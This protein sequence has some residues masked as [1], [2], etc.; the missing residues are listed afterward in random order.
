MKAYWILLLALTGIGAQTL[1][2]KETAPDYFPKALKPLP[3]TQSDKALIELGRALFY[4]PIL[5][6]DG[7]IS[8]ASCH[9][10][11]NGFAHSDH[12]TS[13]GIND[14]VG[15]R[16]APALFNLAWQKEFMWDGAVNNLEMQA[17]APLSHPDEMGSNLATTLNK[18]NESKL[19]QELSEAAYG[20]RVLDSRNFLHALGS[21]LLNLRSWQSKYDRV[22]H[23]QTSFNEQEQRGYALFQSHCNGC[24]TEPLFF[25]NEFR[26]NG[27]AVDSI[28]QDSGRVAVSLKTID[29]YRFKTP[30]LRNLSYTYP[31]MHD[32]RFD[33][34]NQVLRH[35]SAPAGNSGNTDELI[36]KGLQLNSAERT[37]LIAFLLC[38]NDSSFVFNPQYAFPRNT[39]LKPNK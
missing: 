9:S 23:G 4:D 1:I 37:D 31:Y 35:Y 5:S 3:D 14:H 39:L 2:E 29:R 18:L 28:L 26:N 25:A 21:F 7:S 22:K 24:H 12:R 33:N 15:K 34:L 8:C 32:G 16:N 20:T 38:L 36:G 11:Y 19:Y 6:A 27:L 30:S 13:H 17:L 10:V